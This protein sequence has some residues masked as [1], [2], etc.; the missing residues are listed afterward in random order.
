M[1]APTVALGIPHRG[2][3]PGYFFDSA[4]GLIKPEGGVYTLRVEGKPVDLARNQIVEGFLSS[5]ATHLFF[6]DADMKFAPETL[7]RLID[8]DLPIVS[9]VYFA[10]TDHP[11]PHVYDYVRTD[12]YGERW[13]HPKGE[14]LIEWM[15]AHPEHRDAP[16]AYCFGHRHLVKCDGIGGGCLLVRRDV[17]EAIGPPWFQNA[18]GSAGGEDFDFCEKAIAAGYEIYADFAVQ[19]DHEA[20]AVFTGRSE[21]VEAFGVG[22]PGECDFHGPLV[23][24]VGPTG[25]SRRVS[26]DDIFHFPYAVEGY[27]DPEEGRSLFRLALETPP[28]GVIVELGSYKGKSAICLAQAGRR[29]YCVDSFEGEPE[30][31]YADPDHRAGCY[32]EALEAN[33]KRYVPTARVTTIQN[34]TA[35]CGFTYAGDPVN[36]LFVDAAHDEASVRADVEAWLPHIAP[37]GV[38]AFHDSDFEG[39]AAVI[40]DLLGDGWEITH[41]QGS[42]AAMKR[43]N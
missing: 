6:M 5:D 22:E 27:L 21:F 32:R 1:D 9:G 25:R 31:P 34:N 29:L 39:V 13:Y 16:N 26:E 14:A 30:N 35:A 18:Q 7:R 23:V 11:V 4:M 8:A 38:L 2:P 33:L 10:R 3:L 40:D 36:L 42:L 17:F 24:Q 37:D 15:R 12:Q 41:A 43:S 19:C 20:V 28:D